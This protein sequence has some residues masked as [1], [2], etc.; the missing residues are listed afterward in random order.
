MGGEFKAMA[1]VYA[2]L[3]V[4]GVLTFCD[5]PDILKPQVALYLNELGVP[6]LAVCEE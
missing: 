4:R 3:I 2:T 6:E 1:V 5:V